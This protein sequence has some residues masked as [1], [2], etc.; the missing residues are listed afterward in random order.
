LS[1]A[2]QY[3]RALLFVLFDTIRHREHL[4]DETTAARFEFHVS[5]AQSFRRGNASYE[6]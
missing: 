3:D 2:Q 4:G 6:A 5:L 1:L